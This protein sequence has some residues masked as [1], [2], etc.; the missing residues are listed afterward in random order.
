M[1]VTLLGPPG[2]GKGTQGKALATALGLPHIVSS[3]LLHE[4]AEADT[5]GQVQHA[6]ADGNLL[7][8]D[9]VIDVVRNRLAAADVQ[10][11]FVL[12]GFP[13][14]SAQA[15]ALDEWLAERSQQLDAAILL[16]VPRRVL[17]ER[18]AH[19]A[20]VEGRED[21]DPQT[22]HH[23]LDV[24][25]GE[26]GPLLDHYVRTGTLRRVDGDGT[27][28]EVQARVLRALDGSLR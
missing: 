28:D 22:W 8:D 3:D 14:T 1:R 6:M 9:V 2:S 15:Q 25:D 24:Y 20:G 18:L 11:G 4:A 5:G 16:D 13:R 7:A 12:D 17:L 23:R 27:V 19:R 21:D 10:A 26:V